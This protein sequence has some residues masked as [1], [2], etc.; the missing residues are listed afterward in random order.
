M[1]K[2][3]NVVKILLLLLI[4][5]ISVESD[6]AEVY[7]LL[8]NANTTNPGKTFDVTFPKRFWTCQA[9]VSDNQTTSLTMAIEGNIK[10]NTYTEIFADSLFSTE[11]NNAVALRQFEYSGVKNVRAKVKS[12]SGSNNPGVSITCIN[13]D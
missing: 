6:S 11:I 1:L 5:I 3:H 8:V 13:S 7:Q 12:F 10:G 9:E 2:K 4:V